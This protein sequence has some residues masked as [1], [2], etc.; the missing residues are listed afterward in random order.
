MLTIIIITLNTKYV[1]KH[2]YVDL[3]IIITLNMFKKMFSPYYRNQI[4]KYKSGCGGVTLR[5]GR[6]DVC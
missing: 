3:I 4:R 2:I 6:G 5:E 1:N